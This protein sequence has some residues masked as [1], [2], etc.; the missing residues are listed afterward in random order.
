MPNIGQLLFHRRNTSY[1]WFLARS[2]SFALSQTILFHAQD[3]FLCDQR[4]SISC[5]MRHMA[6]PNVWCCEAVRRGAGRRHLVSSNKT[7]TSTLD[8]KTPKEPAQ[9][10]TKKKFFR[11]NIYEKDCDCWKQLTPTFSAEIFWIKLE[12]Y[13][14]HL[15]VKHFKRSHLGCKATSKEEIACAMKTFEGYQKT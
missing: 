6:V 10:V 8:W 1:V 13:K 3:T 14:T 12:W 7:P 15:K 9:K 4:S 2:L 11:M 5:D